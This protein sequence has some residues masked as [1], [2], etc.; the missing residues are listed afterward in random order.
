MLRLGCWLADAC[1]SLPQIKQRNFDADARK[2]IK[3]RDV[4]EEEDTIEKQVAGLADLI[5]A[6]DEQKRGE[7]LVSAGFTTTNLR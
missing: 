7:E 4:A 3:K 6:D 2:V 5:I 1:K